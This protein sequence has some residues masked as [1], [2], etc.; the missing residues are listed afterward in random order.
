MKKVWY[1]LV[2]AVLIIAGFIL[3]Y[4]YAPMFSAGDYACNYFAAGDFA[5]G[6]FAAGKFSA[7]IF[8]IGIFSIGI[9]SVSIFNVAI[10]SVGIF[11]IAYKK[12]LPN[13][14]NKETE[15]KAEI[16]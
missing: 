3:N 7:G 15:E 16:V 9:F 6:V 13:M 2:A 11:V 14:L 12:R 10:Y 8:S 5:L 4:T 1:L